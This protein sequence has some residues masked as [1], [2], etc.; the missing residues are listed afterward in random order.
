MKKLFIVLFLIIGVFAFAS[1]PIYVSH[2]Q[3]TNCN[4]LLA[5]VSPIDGNLYVIINGNINTILY[6]VGVD[7]V[8]FHWHNAQFDMVFSRDCKYLQ[9]YEYSSGQ[10]FQFFNVGVHIEY[11]NQ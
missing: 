9:I 5:S 10:T 2:Y 1:T 7:E 8:G 11:I 6:S 3:D 4:L